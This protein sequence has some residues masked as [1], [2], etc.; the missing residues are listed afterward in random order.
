MNNDG[1]A[2]KGLIIPKYRNNISSLLESAKSGRD[3]RDTGFSR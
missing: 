1:P 3:E 2:F